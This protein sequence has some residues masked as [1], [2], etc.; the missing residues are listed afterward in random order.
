MKTGYSEDLAGITFNQGH[1]ACVY[2]LE[3]VYYIHD[4][5]IEI[6]PQLKTYEIWWTLTF[7]KGF[8]HVYKI[9]EEERQTNT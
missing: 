6:F 8:I 3:N 1:L 9:Y 7:M 2:I 4:D 5:V